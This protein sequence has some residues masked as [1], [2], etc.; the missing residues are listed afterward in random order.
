MWRLAGLAL[1][2]L[3]LSA[4]STG[5]E[6][7]AG[8]PQSR[9]APPADVGVAI[10]HL[11]YERTLI[12]GVIPR[13]SAGDRT[14]AERVQATLD[15]DLAA[16]PAL[17]PI[18][19]ASARSVWQREIGDG[20]PLPG[21]DPIFTC[22][23]HLR[24]SDAADL[25][26]TPDTDLPGELGSVELSLLL[27]GRGLA[28]EMRDAPSVATVVDRSQ[29]DALHALVPLLIPSDRAFAAHA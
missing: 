24:Q 14:A 17:E 9:S 25:A 12:S 4:I 20:S 23:V 27:E 28:T 18:G 22:S 13:L 5:A 26:G 15:R 10:V 29:R 11:T 6:A 16:L 8:V 1:V 2:M 21:Q 3:A 19:D 7:S